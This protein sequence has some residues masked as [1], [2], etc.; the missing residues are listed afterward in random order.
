MRGYRVLEVAEHTFV[1]VASAVLAD[2]GADVIKVEHVERGD[3]MRGLGST[4]TVDLSGSVHVLLEH[5]NRGKRS[6]AL[7]LATPE[8][9]DI[10]YRLAARADVFI[11]NKMP[12]VRRRLKIDV[13]DIRAHNPSIIYVRGSG[14][15]A[16]G[17]DA[18]KGGYDHLAFWC[19]A[20]GATGVRLPG[21]DRISTQPGPGYGDSLGG[22]TIAGG[23]A[24]ALLHR[25]RTGEATVV[26]VS[27]LATGMWAGGAAIALSLVQ[28]RP[29]GVPDMGK[30]GGR[31]PLTGIYPTSDGKWV[32]LSCLQGAHYWP[33]MARVLGRPE[34]GTDPRYAGHEAFTAGA[35]EIA[36]ILR[37]EFA[38]RPLAEWK[39]RLADFTG[40]WSPVQ[41]SLEVAD[42]PQVEPNGYLMET[43][44]RDGRPFRLVTV[45]VQFDGSPAAPKRAPEFNEHGDQILA[46]E[47]GMD[48]E[49]ILD[50]KVRGVVA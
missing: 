47:L 17:P 39:A 8:G 41:D 11:T 13:D 16:R 3:A 30:G 40:Q 22:M 12:G 26:D 42:D 29:W 15:G 28:G 32:A 1:P 21:S 19:R 5:S 6:I 14:Y 38:S 36:A 24:A 45:P 2:W 20:G 37:D 7:D 9:V 27:L 25:E 46:E 50:L 48:E 34:L 4:G 44:T 18:D 23:V 35:D 10:V 43:T 49:A 33:D 31:N